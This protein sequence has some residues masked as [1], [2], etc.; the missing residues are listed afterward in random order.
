MKISAVSQLA[1]K[2]FASKDSYK[3]PREKHMLEAEESSA[4]LHFA[5]TSRDR[6]CCKVPAKLSTQRI[7]S[8]IFLPF[9]HIIYTIITHKSKVRLYS[10]RKPQVSLYNTTHLP[11]RERS[12][13]VRNHYSLFSFPL[14]LSYLERRFVPKHNPHLFRVQRV[15]WSLRSFRDLPKEAGETWRM[16]LGSIAGSRKLVKT[17]LQEVHQQQKLGW[18]KYIGQTRLGGSVV[19][20]VLQLIHEWI[21]FDLEGCGKVFHKVLR[22]P[23]Q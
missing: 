15:F 14:P 19:I 6:P 3:R 17:R 16:Q 9:T 2:K 1:R 10:E 7:L 21:N 18:L 22:F 20:H 13:L 11:F 8:V 5:S 23:L 12:S 4:R